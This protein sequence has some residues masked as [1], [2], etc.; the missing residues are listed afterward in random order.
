MEDGF[1]SHS[2][3]Y[4]ILKYFE[5]LVTTTG[6]LPICM[7]SKSTDCSGCLFELEPNCPVRNDPGIRSLL[8]LYRDQYVAHQR[9]RAKQIVYLKKTLK[10][11]KLPIHWQHL[12]TLVIYRCPQLFESPEQIKGLV[13]NNPATFQVDERGVVTLVP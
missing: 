4:V 10:K 2:D 12:A 6:R 3:A 8:R 1:Y 9:M 13:Y 11:Y 7:E 5:R